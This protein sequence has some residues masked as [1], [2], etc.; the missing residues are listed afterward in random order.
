MQSAPVRPGDEVILTI[1][2]PRYLQAVAKMFAVFALPTGILTVWNATEGSPPYTIFFGS[3]FSL[4]LLLTILAARADD[5]PTLLTSTQLIWP[6]RRGWRA[7]ELTEVAGVGMRYRWSQDG[8][9]WSLH[10]W[11]AE[12]RSTSVAVD[13]PQTVSLEDPRGRLRPWTDEQLARISR[14]LAGS[15]AGKVAIAAVAAQVKAVQGTHGVRK[16]RA[17][18]Q[19]S[20]PAYRNELAYWSP[21]GSIGLFRKVPGGSPRPSRRKR[22]HDGDGGSPSGRMH[23]GATAGGPEGEA[24]TGRASR[25]ERARPAR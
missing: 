21:D 7:M 20:G 23:W 15:S 22:R 13:P 1:A 9:S 2:P 5:R 18:Q 25:R 11:P 19:T 12:G 17:R 8:S 4:F 3:F 14:D 6:V 16:K 24:D 10:V